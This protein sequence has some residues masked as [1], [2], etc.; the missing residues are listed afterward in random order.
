MV[1]VAL[2]AAW[3]GALT[4]AAPQ[5]LA[6]AQADTFDLAGAI[7]Q[8]SRGK[9]TVNSGEGILFHVVYDEKTTIVAADGKPGTEDE[10]KVGVRV[11]VLGD[12]DDA[13]EVK[14]RRIEIQPAQSPPASQSPP[15]H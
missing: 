15:Q 2:T 8:K 5:R 9:L 3:L 4:Y 14:A 13:G 12:F 6:A 11:H 7:S 1:I 10:L